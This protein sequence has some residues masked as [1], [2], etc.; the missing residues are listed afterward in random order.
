[1]WIWNYMIWS[2]QYRTAEEQAKLKA[3]WKSYTLD[4]KHIKGL[5]IDLYSDSKF[6]YL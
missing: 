2:Q 3:E 6:K 1:M 5:A 4:S